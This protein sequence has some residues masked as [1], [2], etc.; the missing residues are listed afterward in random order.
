MPRE[1]P[2]ND[3]TRTSERLGAALA[4]WCGLP[5]V[6]ELARRRGADL[7]R[8]ENH[9]KGLA[10]RIE[11]DAAR[12][13]ELLAGDAALARAVR[14]AA[15][16]VGPPAADGPF[17]AAS[18]HELPAAVARGLRAARWFRVG[19]AWSGEWLDC[20]RAGDPRDALA[21][22]PAMLARESAAAAARL[23]RRGAGAAGD[24]LADAVGY[25]ARPVDPSAYVPAA[26]ALAVHT[27]A[28]LGITA[29]EMHALVRN[30]AENRVRWTR[31]LRADGRPATRRA[32]VHLADWLAYLDRRAGGNARRA[33]W[34]RLTADELDA[35]KAAVR[36]AR[37]D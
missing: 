8:L 17:G 13:G 24:D 19:D 9:V 23:G 22:T 25:V 6:G 29:R 28:E 31:P 26:R 14:R 16:E 18:W 33:D 21:A 15:L 7:E 27:P 32:H 20:V 37:G 10:A 3:L 35:R 12:V 5:L 1:N 2:L 30:F 34:P 36:A 4:E 11:G